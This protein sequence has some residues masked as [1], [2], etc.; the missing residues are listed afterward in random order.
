MPKRNTVE[1]NGEHHSTTTD[2]ASRSKKSKAA[3][4]ALIDAANS[5]PAQEFQSLYI[6]SER[7]IYSTRDD[8]R[9]NITF[10]ASSQ[11]TN[12]ELD[13]CLHLID[14]TSRHDY[15]ASSWG[16]HPRRKKRE[17]KEAEM[18]YLLVHNASDETQAIQGFLSFMLTH[19]STPSVPVVYVYEV[20]LAAT[21]RGVGLGAHLMSIAE[22]VAA[23]VGVEKIMLTCFC[24]NEKARAFYEGRGYAVDASSPEDRRTRGKVV[25]VDYV[26]M[27]KDVVK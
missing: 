17:M 16:W 5:R 15:E 13:A 22:S 18:R 20:H 12:D 4:D 14:T 1:A 11:L 26:I 8:T 25:K 6:K 24:S 3:S 10:K 21:W 2:D 7:L 9:L 27:S 19:D 23:E